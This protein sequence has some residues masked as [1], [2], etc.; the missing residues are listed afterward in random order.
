MARS[1]QVSAQLDRAGDEAADGL[2]LSGAIL[3]RRR[4][5]PKGGVGRKG[6]VGAVRQEGLHLAGCSP[7][8]GQAAVGALASV[9]AAAQALTECNLSA[10][11]P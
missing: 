8:A 1:R 10:S 7:H 5:Q 4:G 3:V 2:G 9:C 6:G 11:L